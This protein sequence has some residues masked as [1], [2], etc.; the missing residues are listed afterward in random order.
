V[1]VGVEDLD[2]LHSAPK[3]Q[4]VQQLRL[5]LQHHLQVPHLNPLQNA[6]VMVGQQF[7]QVEAMAGE[8]SEFSHHELA[9]ANHVLS[10]FVFQES[11]LVHTLHIQSQKFILILEQ[12]FA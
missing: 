9:V 3:K 2:Q 7:L 10:C 6:E 11:S 8:V 12:R 4:P 1:L 5:L